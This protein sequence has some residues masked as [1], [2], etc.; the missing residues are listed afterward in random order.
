MNATT[1]S[2]AFR[3][4]PA[5]AAVG[6]ALAGVA[7]G[8]SL[9]SLAAPDGVQDSGALVGVAV[10]IV[11]VL[12]DLAAVG[13]VG[14][15]FLPILL[16]PDAGKPR[17]APVLRIARRAAVVTALLWATGAIVAVLLQTAEHHA[18][19]GAISLDD[20]RTYVAQIAAG[21]AMLIM[22]GFA[23]VHA[24]L[25]VVAIRKG[26]R[27]PPELRAGVALFGILPLPVAGHA[28][29]WMEHDYAMISMELHVLSAAAWAG[30]LGALAVL[31]AGHRTLLATTLPRFSLLATVCIAV[32]AVT[33]LLNG[34]VEIQSHPGVSLLAGL[35]TTP[36][37][38]LVI[39]KVA[40]ISALGTLG[41]RMRWWILPAVVAQRPTAF[42][43]WAALELAVMGLAF[44]FGV[45]LTR[46]PVV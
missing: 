27:V 28:A 11:R 46:S 41:A 19:T 15:S 8:V 35:L 23:M 5:I 33:G 13:T 45:V 18:I 2:L 31:M 30:G 17:A 1:V 20:V 29:T 44:G 42:A 43:R 39:A 40:C 25:G 24:A 10:P 38:L 36:Y 16:G 3:R 37:G 21:K 6:A 22:A 34:I 7:G 32:S 14:L 9:L 26:E 4:H 12:T